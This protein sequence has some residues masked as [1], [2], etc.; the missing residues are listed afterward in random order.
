[1]WPPMT[2]LSDLEDW[3]KNLEV[4]L[5]Q[6]REQV[7]EATDAARIKQ[8]LQRFLVR[9]TCRAPHPSLFSAG[10][11]QNEF[12]SLSH[13]RVHFQQLDVETQTFC[14]EAS[15]KCC[16]H[17]WTQNFRYRFFFFPPGIKDVFSQG[18]ASSGIPVPNSPAGDGIGC[19]GWSRRENN[20]RRATR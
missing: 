9:P 11:V 7:H 3:L 6:A 4:H 8:S 15:I 1:M 19:S 20:V 10:L 17:D 14:D 16:M 13:H 18:A 2:L 5:E 12:N